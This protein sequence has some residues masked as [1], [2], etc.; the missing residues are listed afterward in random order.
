MAAGSSGSTRSSRRRRSASTTS[1]RV[2]WGFSDLDDLMI[3]YAVTVHKSQGSEYR[4]VIIPLHTAHYMMLQ[5]NLLYTAVTRAKELVVLVGSW[6]ALAI[7]LKSDRVAERY[8]SLAQR[9]RDDLA[10]RPG[11]RGEDHPPAREAPPATRRQPTG[12]AATAPH[13]GRACG[14]SRGM[15]H[16]TSPQTPREGETMIVRDRPPTDPATRAPDH[17][18]DRGGGDDRAPRLGGEGVDRE[19]DRRRGADRSRSSCA[20]A[21]RARSGSATTAR[22]S[23]PTSCRSAFARHATSKLRDAD[24]LWRIGSLGFRGEALAS[25]G[26]MGETLLISATDDGGEGAGVLVSN[27]QIVESFAA[28]RARGTTVT[29]RSLFADVPAR[30]KFMRPARTESAQVNTLV[31]RYCPRPHRYSL[32]PRPRRPPVV[33]LR[34]GTTIWAGR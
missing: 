28:P 30:L 10:R 12:P 16:G 19:R 18:A 29:V 13:R 25:I 7:A 14:V 31:R 32:P 27:G 20:G 33:R 26:A 8:T 1:G 17:R 23:P 2:T 3:A 9:L 15:S 6:R 21:A 11:E 22:G 34:R 4:A 5:R 24:D